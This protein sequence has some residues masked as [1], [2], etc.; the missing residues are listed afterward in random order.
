MSNFYDIQNNHYGDF[1]QRQ[2]S[3]FVSRIP[4][5]LACLHNWW[6]WV[7]STGNTSYALH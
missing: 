1:N 2:E 4:L 7:E 3:C 6:V 5:D